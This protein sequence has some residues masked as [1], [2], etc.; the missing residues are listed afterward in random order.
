MSFL[1]D[2]FGSADYRD[3]KKL[4]PKTQ[5]TPV[6]RRNQQLALPQYVHAQQDIEAEA[7]KQLEPDHVFENV[8]KSRCVTIGIVA[9]Q[10]DA[11][12]IAIDVPFTADG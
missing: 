5:P 2:R 7:G 3:Q 8:R 12:D 4:N 10:S 9:I 6:S 11:E 1:V